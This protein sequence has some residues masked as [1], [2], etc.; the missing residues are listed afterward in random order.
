[1]G[2]LTATIK[3]FISNKNTVTIL[4]VLAG[5]IV[6]WYFYNQRVE[7]AITTIRIP[8]AI[9]RIDPGTKIEMDN[10]D[11]VEITVSTTKDTDI[12]KSKAEL[13]GKYLCYGTSV[14]TNGF[15]FAS[16]VCE[17]KELPNSVIDDIPDGYAPYALKVNSQSTYANSIL[18]GN[19]IDLYMSAKDDDGKIIY[20]PLIKSIEVLAVRDNSGKDVFWDQNAGDSAYLL[21]GVPAEYQN[22]LVT[23]ELITT[24]SIQITPVPR[25]SSY[26][27]NPGDTQVGS[28]YLYNFVLSKSAQIMDS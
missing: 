26:T 22:L 5:V 1:M 19:Y 9:N 3:R 4:A 14:P 10:I 11:L 15:I 12:I 27:A 17:E 8:F 6:L 28:D 24:N 13:E 18:P 7:A 21:F 23:A 20:G 2:N 16:Q 25:N